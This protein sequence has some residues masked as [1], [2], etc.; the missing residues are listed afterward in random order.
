M[1]RGDAKAIAHYKD[2]RA[3]VM[4]KPNTHSAMYR[5]AARITQYNA[6]ADWFSC[7]ADQGNAAAAHSV[8]YLLGQG[9]QQDYTRRL[10]LK[11][12]AQGN[13]YSENELGWRVCS[14]WGLYKIMDSGTAMVSKAA[15]QGLASAQYICLMYANGG[16]QANIPKARMVY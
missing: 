7:A 6:A 16:T 4:P 2:P 5:S 9:T 12:A 3:K 15:E 1:L 8:R 10:C 13:P 14:W 11:T